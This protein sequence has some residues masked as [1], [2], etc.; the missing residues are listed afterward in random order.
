[1]ETGPGER[2]LKTT[3]FSSCFGVESRES[4]TS[5]GDFK[6]L[7]RLRG[8][9]LSK[10]V[11]RCAAKTQENGQVHTVVP[12]GFLFGGKKLWLFEIRH[13][14]LLDLHALIEIG[15]YARMLCFATHLVETF[16]QILS[17]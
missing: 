15:G 4:S 5:P 12:G 10:I 6:P 17:L 3:G 14:M 1:M 16:L 13:V 11:P 7:Y 9:S 8:T 2:D